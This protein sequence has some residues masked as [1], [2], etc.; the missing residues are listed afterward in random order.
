MNEIELKAVEVQLGVLKLQHLLLTSRLKGDSPGHPFRGNQWSGGGGG[1][2]L[3]PDTGGGS[4]GGTSSGGGSPESNT[5]IG[6]GGPGRFIGLGGP[7]PLWVPASSKKPI[8]SPEEHKQ[9]ATKMADSAAKNKSKTIKLQIDGALS[10]NPVITPK[11]RQGMK[12]GGNM[13]GNYHDAKAVGDILAKDKRITGVSILINDNDIRVRDAA[14]GN[15][16]G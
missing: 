5:H 6:P 15:Y 16:A 8:R 12:I 11:N 7:D 13:K 14:M 4:G 3:A 10:D 9:Y 1:P 2:M